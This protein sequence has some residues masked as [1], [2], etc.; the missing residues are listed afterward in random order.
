M[1]MHLINSK[2]KNTG[3][4]SAPLSTPPLAVLWRYTRLRKCSDSVLLDF[5]K[6]GRMICDLAEFWE[7][8]GRTRV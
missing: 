8:I 7:E 4:G 5:L 2:L 1:Q 6:N 3:G